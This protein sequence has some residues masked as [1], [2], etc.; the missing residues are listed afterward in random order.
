M[1]LDGPIILHC[2]YVEQGQSIDEMCARAV[3]WGFDGVEFRRKRSAVEESPTDY[4]DAIAR[5]REASGLELVLFGGPACDMMNAEA[6]AREASLAEVESFYREAAKRFDLGVNNLFASPMIA[7]GGDPLFF[8]RNGSAIATDRDRDLAVEGLRRLGA[9][10]EE[11]GF[12]FALEL[13]NN[14][15]HD[16]AQ[17]SRD[18][19]DRVGL[20][21]VGL[22][23]DQGN[24]QLN[25]NG[26]PVEES[27]RICG[28]KLYY[29][30]LKNNYMVAGLEYKNYIPCPLSDG[31]INN[32]AFLRELKALDYN[33]PLCIEGP[34]QGD[35]E[36]FARQDLA[37]VRALLDEV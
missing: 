9:L 26:T 6:S 32:R 28:E 25:T 1:A 16:L 35:R 5:A 17:P 36:W 18:L 8:D 4:L 20:E 30:H 10:A 15:L 37:Y 23:L 11:L 3:A 2:N 7:P 29:V 31:G 22:N 19:V 33:G 12:R 24:I 14:Y 13:H 27:V 34:R 21:T